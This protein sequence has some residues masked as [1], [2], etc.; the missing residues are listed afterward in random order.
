MYI[1]F[2]W[3]KSFAQ[4]RAPHTKFLLTE[5]L[6]C[7]MEAKTTTGGYFFAYYETLNDYKLSPSYDLAKTID[8]HEREM[9]V[10][11]NP[12]PTEQDLMKL[13]AYVGLGKGRT[14]LIVERIKKMI[15]SI[16]FS[17]NWVAK[18]RQI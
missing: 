15:F 10:M 2:K 12:N 1:F 9:T 13:A 18:Y 16:D 17:T 5:H 11:G 8:K 14:K 7:F 4:I 3:F 6:M